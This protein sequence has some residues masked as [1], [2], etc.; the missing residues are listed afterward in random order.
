MNNLEKNQS[1]CAFFLN[2]PVCISTPTLNTIA[3]GLNLPTNAAKTPID[4]YNAVKQISNCNS[5]SC[6]LSNRNIINIIGKKTADYEKAHYLKPD[7][8]RDNT[9]WFSNVEIDEV[10]TQWHVAKPYFYN[11]PYGVRDYDEINHPLK[12]ITPY[13]LYHAHRDS[14]SVDLVERKKFVGGRDSKSGGAQYNDGYKCFGCVIN[15][16]VSTGPGKHWMAIFG[17]MRDDHADPER[18]RVWTVEYFNSSSIRHEPFVKYVEYAANSMRRIVDEHNLD[19]EVKAEVVCD[20][21]HQKSKTECGPYSMYYIYK[22]LF[23][24]IDCNEFKS[25]RVPD[26]KMYEFRQLLF[27]TDK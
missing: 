12:T 9:N 10:L 25:R 18:N 20:I 14:S 3:R 2:S 26:E 21:V 22:R 8:P 24:D 7:G 15:T 17:D 27:R 5:E 19:V 1:D 11:Y 23:D 16:D 4:T 13:D 6:I